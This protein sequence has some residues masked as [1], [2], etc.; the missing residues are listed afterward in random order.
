MHKICTHSCNRPHSNNEPIPCHFTENH[1]KK[2]SNMFNLTG[3]TSPLKQV[4]R[5]N[6]HSMSPI[7][8]S[9]FISLF[10]RILALT[11]YTETRQQK[12]QNETFGVPKV[13]EVTWNLNLKFNHPYF[14]IFIYSTSIFTTCTTLLSIY[15]IFSF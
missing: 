2:R 14:N 6:L 8:L 10:C 3:E 7:V 1:V 5:K 9:L 11:G 13:K 4:N 12:L 15:T